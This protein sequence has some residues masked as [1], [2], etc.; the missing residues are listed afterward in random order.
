MSVR[1]NIYDQPI[2][3]EIPNWTPRAK[4]SRM[5]IAGR[6]CR[7]EP[8]QADCHAN[9]LFEAL[10]VA[11][12]DSDWTYLIAGPFHDKA[13]YHEYAE[14]ISKSDD[15]LH[16]AVI[17]LATGLALG[18]LALMRIDAANGVMEVGYVTYSPKLQRT[19]AATEAHYLLM[20]Y[21]FDELGYRRYEWK[22]DNLNAPSRA[23]AL[24]MGFQFE[25]IFRQASVYK[26]R[27][28]DTAWFSMLDSEWPSIRTGFELWLAAENFDHNG[29][30]QQK[31]A[32]LIKLQ[33]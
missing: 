4:P 14:N 7:L 29:Q 20:R 18:T 6:Y 22:C 13:S 5:P 27:N 15:P 10:K 33:K 31:L 3:A 9:D 26:G 30:Q 8:L 16:F 11:S 2:S 24:R 17:D 28:R 19:R 23:A 21:A 25:G 32:T 1:Y 12:N